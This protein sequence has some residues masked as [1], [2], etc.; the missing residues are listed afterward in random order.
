MNRRRTVKRDLGFGSILLL[1]I[2][3]VVIASVGVFH[4]SVKNRQVNVAREIQTLENLISQH[5]LDIKTDN[6]RLGEQLNR[7]LIRDRLREFSS[8]L[9][10]IPGKAIREVGPAS[11]DAPAVAGASSDSSPDRVPGGSAVA[12]LA[13]SPAPPRP[14]AVARPAPPDG[15]AVTGTP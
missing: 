3:A 1:V 15:Y 11:R 4:A 12:G 14:S 7:F 5:E 10:P 13:R 2:A 6:M 8:D 9:R